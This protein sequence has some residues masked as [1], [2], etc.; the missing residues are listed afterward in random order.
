MNG[1][2][3]AWRAVWQKLYALWGSFADWV[4]RLPVYIW[5]CVGAL[6]PTSMSQGDACTQYA[7]LKLYYLIEERTPYPSL[8][9]ICPPVSHT[10]GLQPPDLLIWAQCGE[11]SYK[12][13]SSLVS[14]S[15]TRA[16]CGE[17]AEAL[18]EDMARESLR[19]RTLTLKLKTSAF[20]ARAMVCCVHGTG[21]LTAH[22]VPNALPGPGLLSSGK[23][24]Q[25]VI[26]HTSCF[27]ERYPAPESLM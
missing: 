25:E 18:A 26:L 5:G 22:E 12:P 10:F 3:R 13:S 21:L 6:V 27:C 11:L 7:C 16:Q 14:P 23:E 4:G 15:L 2:G 19:G 8:I 9:L 24:M 20:E 1:T 17:L